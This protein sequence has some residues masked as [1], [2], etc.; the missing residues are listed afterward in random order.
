MAKVAFTFFVITPFAQPQ[1]YGLV[2]VIAGLGV[3]FL[4]VVIG[5]MLDGRK[6][7]EEDI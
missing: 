6:I 1:S 2:R 7:T 3:G 5:Y 4:L